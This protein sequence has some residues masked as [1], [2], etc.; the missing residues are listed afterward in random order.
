MATQ[1]FVNGSWSPGRTWTP[2]IVMARPLSF[3]HLIRTTKTENES[4]HGGELV[5]SCFLVHSRSD[6]C[7]EDYQLV[8]VGG[9]CPTWS[10]LVRET[11]H[12]LTSTSSFHRILPSPNPGSKLTPVS[13]PSTKRMNSPFPPNGDG[14]TT[15][16]RRCVG[17]WWSGK[18][19]CRS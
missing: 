14:A 8:D 12:R 2:A 13:P 7:W 9:F 17:S 6:S 15:P 19:I 4:D 3:S 5:M 18:R 10:G 11:T 16:H 1:S